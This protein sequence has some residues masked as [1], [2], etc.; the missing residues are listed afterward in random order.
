MM[1]F[2]VE[3]VVFCAQTACVLEASVNKPG[4]VCPDHDFEDTSYTDFIVSAVSIGQAVKGAVEFGMLFTPE[5]PGVGKLI[6][7][8]VLDSRKR[9]AGR[10]TNLGLAMLII[11]L[12]V[13]AGLC[14]KENRFS[15]KHLR[16]GVGTLL[17]GSTP[18][19][20]LELYDAVTAS[21]AE[22]G[23]SNRFDVKAPDSKKRVLEKKLNLYDILRISSWDA[24]AKELVNNMEISFTLGYPALMNEYRGTK[25]LRRAV[26]RCF[27]EILSTVPDTLIERKN[28]REAALEIT[29]QA[30]IILEKGLP[31]KDVASLDSK[32]RCDKNRYNP[33]TTADLTG[34]S[35]MVALLDGMLI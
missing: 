1:P 8:A 22:V 33:G 34:A 17:K 18:E 12:S 2:T 23:R 11:P 25:N 5:K 14:I 21:E 9:H 20:T 30:K 4:N 15:L 19:D 16:E 32:L 27:F 10:N 26:L 29:R 31:E 7:K 3:D 24:V 35:L 28:N 6:K 13:S